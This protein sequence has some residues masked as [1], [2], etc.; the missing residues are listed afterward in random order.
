MVRVVESGALRAAGVALVLFLLLPVPARAQT[1]PVPVETQLPLFLKVLTFDRNLQQSAGDELVIAILFQPRFRGSL[2]VK[3]G[4]ER[5]AVASEIT[6]V[7]GV[8]FRL[9]AVDLDGEE[10][11]RSRIVQSEA[12]VLYIAP[13]RAVQIET[14]TGISRDLRL[15]T[16]SGAPEYING[17]V[18]VSIEVVRSSPRLVINLEAAEQQGADFSSRLLNLARVVND[19]RESS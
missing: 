14:I 15:V 4:L 7:G 5:A 18:A 9:V 17:G 3:E 12:D 16:L 11:L 2:L 6:T 19:H 10:E 13:L 1:L 8:P